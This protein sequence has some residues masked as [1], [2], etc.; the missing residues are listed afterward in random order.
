MKRILSLLLIIALCF[1]LTPSTAS[2]AVKINKTKATV[3]IGSTVKLKIAGTSK[4]VMWT[5]DNKE[6][7]KVS[8]GT[9][10][11]VGKGT[12]TITAT[13]GSGSD[14]QK[15]TCDVTVK[16]RL[17]T[18]TTDFEF[19]MDE[20]IE[21]PISIKNPKPDENLVYTI[22]SDSIVSAEWVEGDGHVLR[23]IPE[24]PGK[25]SIPVNIGAGDLRNYT[26]NEDDTLT[27]NIVINSDSEWISSAELEN[28][29]VS[30]AWNLYTGV[31][32]FIPH[33]T[34]WL[35]ESLYEIDTS[36]IPHPFEDEKVYSVDGIEFKVKEDETYFKIE[37]LKEKKII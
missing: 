34:S 26:I 28:L 16:S 4:Y 23:I 37:S 5:S 13:V 6:I 10:T 35:T 1:I 14:N 32:E 36:H 30:A 3:Y 7:A 12:T 2:A 22:D 21:V 24:K 33:S 8:K 9:V 19:L 11:G 29:G 27:I 15:F 20:Y 17:S 25:T 31:L 18:K